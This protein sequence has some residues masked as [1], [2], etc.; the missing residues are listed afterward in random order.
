MARAI[1]RRNG[2]D[3]VRTAD[4]ELLEQELRSRRPIRV[5][6]VRKHAEFDGPTGHIAGAICVPLHRLD[7]GETIGCAHSDPIVVVSDRG[8]SARLAAFELELLGF[9]EVRSLEGGMA[10]WL[11]LGFPIE[12]SQSRVPKPLRLRAKTA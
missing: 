1:A 5:V 11:E 10:R 9:T 3:Q 7:G 6:D 12:R 4:A 2:I 8:V